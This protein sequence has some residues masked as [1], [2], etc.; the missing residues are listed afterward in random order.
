M[1][2]IV[3]GNSSNISQNKIDT[4]VLVKKNYLRNTHIVANFE[5]HIDLRNQFR[6]KSLPDPISIREECSQTC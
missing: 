4:S 2:T 5:E 6:I 1:S 3:F